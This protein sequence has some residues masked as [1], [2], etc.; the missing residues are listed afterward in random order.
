M[1]SIIADQ[2]V[3]TLPVKR[4]HVEHMH[5]HYHTRFIISASHVL[6]KKWVG[7][8]TDLLPKN[9]T[10]EIQGTEKNIYIGLQW[11][12]QNIRPP[13]NKEVPKSYIQN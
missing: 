2:A 13:Y 10:P 11:D 1:N 4:P 5:F 9:Y 6:R 8:F 7:G 3:R 12:I